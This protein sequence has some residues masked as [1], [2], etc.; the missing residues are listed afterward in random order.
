MLNPIRYLLLR[1]NVKLFHKARDTDADSSV[2]WEVHLNWNR[3]TPTEIHPF[4]VLKYWIWHSKKNCSDIQIVYCV[5]YSR[6]TK[7]YDLYFFEL[8]I[9]AIGYGN[10]NSHRD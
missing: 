10:Y 6:F 8:S 1:I 7:N 5:E 4:G 9:V 3:Y 2:N